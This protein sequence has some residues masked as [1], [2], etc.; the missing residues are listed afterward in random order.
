M[1]KTNPTTEAQARAAKLAAIGSSRI[2]H[3]DDDELRDWLDMKTG[4]EL[5]AVQIDILLDMVRA[6]HRRLAS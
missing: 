6:A 4:G 1:N 3:W 2:G 5:D